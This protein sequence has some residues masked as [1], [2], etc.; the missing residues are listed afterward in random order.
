M[1][2]SE[3]CDEH[4]IEKEKEYLDDGEILF[5]CPLCDWNRHEAYLDKWRE[6]DK[7]GKKEN[8]WWPF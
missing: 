5:H 8:S 7:K 1:S 6:Q 3:W 4:N 2:Q